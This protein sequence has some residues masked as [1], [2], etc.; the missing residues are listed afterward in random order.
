M[1][2]YPQLRPEE[3]SETADDM[4]YSSAS[5]NTTVTTATE[6]TPLSKSDPATPVKVLSFVICALRLYNRFEYIVFIY[7][8]L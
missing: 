2:L 1:L 7:I 4:T 8:Y 3:K 5:D 6:N